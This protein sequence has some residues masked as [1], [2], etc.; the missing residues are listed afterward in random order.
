MNT[1]NPMLAKL[2][3]AVRRYRK[4]ADLTQIELAHR[5]PCSDK[6][7]SAIET[8]R[9]RP[10]EKLIIAIETALG[11]PPGALKDLYDRMDT[12][13][14]QSWQW[15]WFIEESRALDLRTYDLTTA[16]GLL[17]IEEYARALLSGNDALVRVRL[18]RQAILASDA[19]PKLSVLIDEMALHREIGGP[20]VMYDQLT[21]LA[22]SVSKRIAVRVVSSRRDTDGLSGAFTIARIDSG[23]VAYVETGI[24]GIV[25][26]NPDDIAYLEDAWESIGHH[27]LSQR[28]SL[29]LIRRTAEKRWRTGGASRIAG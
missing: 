27:A 14:L 16:P 23:K 4:Q 11:V 26:S 3:A 6:T 19:P 8:G 12:E 9:E 5:V 17:Q 1:S 18:D 15:A 29:D 7:I 21:H 28:E 2:A 25:T 20:Q 10:S 13:S 22:E 24:R